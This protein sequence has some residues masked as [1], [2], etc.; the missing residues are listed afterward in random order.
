MEMADTFN[1]L[2]LGP[3][4]QLLN[5]A[6]KGAKQE[7]NQIANN[8]ANVNTPGFHT[9]SIDFRSALKASIE[10]PEDPDTLAL[11]TDDD[12]QFEIGQSTEP[13]PYAP[14][15]QVDTTTQMRVDGS[16]VD[17]DQQMAELSGNTGYQQTMSQFLSEQY[18]FLREAITEQTN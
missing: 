6:V 10:A 7:H 11:T 18:K 15:P 14:K 9:S 16:N 12:R 1:I 2:P 8:I 3:T 17:I 13:V 5:E 4:T